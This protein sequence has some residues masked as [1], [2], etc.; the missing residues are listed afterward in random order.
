M[1]DFSENVARLEPSP[2]LAITARAKA[3]QAEGCS[4]I[5]LSAG[6]PSFSTPDVAADGSSRAVA[7][8]QTGYP[9]TPGIPE[10]RS[11]VARYCNETTAESSTEASNV[12]VSA[13]VKQVLFN[14]SYCLFGPGDEVL[15]PS[16]YWPT[17]LAT[18]DL[19]RATPVTVPLEWSDGFRLSV[20]RLEA[21]R[22][23]RTKGIFL[24][25]P[26]NPSGAVIAQG[27]LEEILT[28]AG[29]HDVWVLSD[30]IYRRLYFGDGSAPS[31]LDIPDRPSRVVALDGMSKT[32]SMP[33]WRIGWGVGPADLMAKAAALQSQTT[34]GAA[35]PSQYASVALLNSPER[36]SIIEDFRN[37]LGR[38]RASSL[39]VLRQVAS[40]EVHDQPGAIY[41]YLRLRAGQNSMDTAEALLTQAGVATIPGEAFGTPGYLR[42]TFAGADAPLADGIRRIAEFFG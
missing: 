39:A 23:E 22:T 3:M 38:R 29:K 19:S 4:V 11:A 37:T 5:D 1:L 26:S 33:G 16:P 9:P 18:V 8:G 12:L 20:E 32:F 7:A 13:G 15:I 42:I 28:W 24:N 21:H 17:Y 41:H 2:T 40:I 14:L 30:E 25:S 34:S 10:L 6:E 27:D 35:G 31:V 36:E